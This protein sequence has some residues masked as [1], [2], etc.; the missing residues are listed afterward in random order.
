MVKYTDRKQRRR[1]RTK[2]RDE[3]DEHQGDRAAARS[4]VGGSTATD[5][6]RNG[7]EHCDQK[8]VH[9]PSRPEVV[10]KSGGPTIGNHE[11]WHDTPRNEAQ[12][13][14]EAH[15]RVKQ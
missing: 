12:L 9:I 15:I 8:R 14:N 4:G 2:W 1:H 5:R 11:I 10:R 6:D 7:K 3:D 13:P